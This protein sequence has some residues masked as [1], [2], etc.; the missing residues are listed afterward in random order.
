MKCVLTR[1][2][3]YRNYLWSAVSDMQRVRSEVVAQRKKARKQEYKGSKQ[4]K[5]REWGSDD[6]SAVMWRERSFIV[7]VSYRVRA[8][9]LIGLR[10]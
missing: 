8:E 9:C 7:Y 6:L 4:G 10:G 2:G 1:V 3:F 5:V